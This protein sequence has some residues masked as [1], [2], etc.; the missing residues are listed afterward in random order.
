MRT[1]E[2]RVAADRA[3]AQAH[4]TPQEGAGLL[5]RVF[6][7]NATTIRMAVEPTPQPRGNLAI[8]AALETERS[9]AAGREHI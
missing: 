3:F 4:V 9:V 8:E 6:G 2:V 5:E 7:T 1:A